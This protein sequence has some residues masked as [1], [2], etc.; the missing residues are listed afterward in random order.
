MAAGG[1]SPASGEGRQS[2]HPETPLLTWYD[3]PEAD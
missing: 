3:T 1:E 2:E